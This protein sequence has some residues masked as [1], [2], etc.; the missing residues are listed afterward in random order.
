MII[1]YDL[2]GDYMVRVFKHTSILLITQFT[3]AVESDK[4]CNNFSETVT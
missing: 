2:S 1:L 4:E 3:L